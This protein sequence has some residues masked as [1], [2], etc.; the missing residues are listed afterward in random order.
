MKEL[1]KLLYRFR[2]FLLF[3]LLQGICFWLII[4]HNTY[5][6][7]TV[8][9]SANSFIGGILNIQNWVTTRWNLKE[10]NNRL[11]LENA[12]LHTLLSNQIRQKNIDN[13]LT[14]SEVD[15]TKNKE[16]KNILDALYELELNLKNE[17][18]LFLLERFFIKFFNREFF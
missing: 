17:Q 3:L 18:V 2:N 12:R 5:Q 10:E 16:L 13:S 6:R 4:N 7:I 8:L 14:F 11:L 1:F 9:T 15:S